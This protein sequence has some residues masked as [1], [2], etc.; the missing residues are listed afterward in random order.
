MR[1]RLAWLAKSRP[2]WLFEISQLAKIT[3]ETFEKERHALIRKLNKAVK[4]AVDNRL[5]LR[6]NKLDRKSLRIIEFSDSSFA[7]NRE[8]SSQLGHIVFLGDS[9][10]AVIPLSF[11]SY[12]ARRITR[13]AMSG[14]VI[15]FSDMFDIAIALR[16]DLERMLNNAVPFHLLTDSKSLFDV[17]SKGFRTSEKRMMLDIGAAREAFRDKIISDIGFVRSHLNIADGLTKPMCQSL[18]R[19][20]ISTRYLDVQPEQWIVRSPEVT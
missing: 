15:A 12:K 14:E 13:S 19:D 18:L 6:I 10:N 16:Q 8:L 1:M 4:Y 3:E 17:I 2:D 5:R 7:N 11:K 20:T 9:S